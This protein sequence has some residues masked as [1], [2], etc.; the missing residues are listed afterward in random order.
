MDMVYKPLV[1]PLLAQARALG[2]ATV[3]G[4][5][6]L[7]GQAAVAFRLFFGL[8]PP[9]DHDEDLRARLVA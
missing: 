7:I 5:D 2:M 3:D 9:R 1:T 4:L 6:M 8:Q